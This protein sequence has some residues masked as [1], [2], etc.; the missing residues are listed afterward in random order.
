[1]DS[2]LG[3]VKGI[4][5]QAGVSASSTQGKIIEEYLPKIIILLREKGGPALIYILSD[6]ERL[7]ELSRTAYQALPMPVRLVVKEQQFIDYMLSQRE[8]IAEMIRTQCE[9]PAVPMV[10]ASAEELAEDSV[11]E[12][13]EELVEES[14]EELAGESTET[15]YLPQILP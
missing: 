13:I 12:T 8:R 6:T 10:E 14:V 1:M 9:A 7:S 15:V 5:S 11:E 3:R 2:F 4:A